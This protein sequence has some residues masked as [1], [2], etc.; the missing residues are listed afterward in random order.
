MKEEILEKAVFVGIIRQNDDERKVMEYLDELEFLA[1]LADTALT[2]IR[3]TSGE[4]ELYGA[5]AQAAKLVVTRLV[6]GA[7]MSMAKVP[8]AERRRSTI[9]LLLYILLDGKRSLYDAMK[10]YEYEMDVTF[11][12][13]DYQKQIDML[14]YLEK[15]GYV[16]I[17]ER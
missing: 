13:N 12:D 4:P 14:R 6:P 15:Y 5:M 3:K 17:R 11:S 1:E 10:L 9:D 16:Q 7:L 8:H 2:G